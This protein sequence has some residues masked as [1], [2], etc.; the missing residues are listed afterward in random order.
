V[1]ERIGA[2][3]RMN[4][5]DAAW[6]QLTVEASSIIDVLRRLSDSARE[7]DPCAS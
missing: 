6:R 4:A 3:S 7:A 2:E 5:A 1:L